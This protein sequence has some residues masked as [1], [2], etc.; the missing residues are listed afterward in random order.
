M[1]EA[2]KQGV[3]F[4]IINPVPYPKRNSTQFWKQLTGLLWK[5]YM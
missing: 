1:L 5:L 2:I 4:G 3:G